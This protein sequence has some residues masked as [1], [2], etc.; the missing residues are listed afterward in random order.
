MPTCFEM[1]M[2]EL[3]NMIIWS[4]GLHLSVI[5]EANYSLVQPD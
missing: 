1:Y 5:C 4:S 2:D 3:A